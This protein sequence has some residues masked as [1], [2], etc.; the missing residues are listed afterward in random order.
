MSEAVPMQFAPTLPPEEVARA[1]FYGLI[2]RLFYAPPDAALLEAIAG[3][4]DEEAEDGDFGDAWQAL[5]RAASQADPGAVREEYENAFVGTGKAPVTLYTSA[6]TIRFE[7]ETPLVE[8]RAQLSDLGL[9]RKSGVFEPEDH[10]A[11]LCDVMRHLVAEQKRDLHEQ[12][13]F[14]GRWIAPAA[15]PL[16]AAIEASEATDFYKFAGRFAKAFFAIEQSAF[17]ML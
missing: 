3:A 17:E 12:K 15:E 13:R 8:L 1:N 10:V 5:A 4:Q 6:Y 9:S 2:A 7:S 11:A 16:C 14:F